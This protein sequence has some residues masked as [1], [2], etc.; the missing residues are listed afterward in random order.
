MRDDTVARS[1]AETLF[2]LARRNDGIE[3]YGEGIETV[4]R[5]LDENPR[6]REFLETP[7]IGAADKKRVVRKA[8]GAAL[9]KPLVNFLLVTIDKR[10]QRL[11]RVMAREY[12]A[13][14]DEH[15]DRIHVEVTV[16]RPMD[17]AT[18]RQVT[19]RLGVLLGR[20]AIP[21]VR[22]KPEVLGGVMVRAGDTIYDGSV[23]RRL[24]DM[25]RRLMAADLPESAARGLESAPA[26]TD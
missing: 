3:G 7:R 25:R 24:E 5:L 10:R 12:H 13:L 1:Y 20:T 2:E 11:L 23:R 17:E 21:H 9:P 26:G 14:V 19:E 15:L 4:A 8:F 22:V 18:T 6:L 16:A